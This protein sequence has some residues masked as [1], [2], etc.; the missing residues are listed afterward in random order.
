MDNLVTKHTHTADK[1]K[2]LV[3]IDECKKYLDKYDLSDEQILQLNNSLIGIV[4][5]IINSYLDEFDQ[6]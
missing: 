1:P 4:E 2:G 3:S 5:S 6:T